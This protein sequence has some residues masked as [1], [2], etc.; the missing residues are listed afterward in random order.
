VLLVAVA[1]FGLALIPVLAIQPNL[2]QPTFSMRLPIVGGVYIVICMLGIL[3]VFYPAKCKEVFQKSQNPMPQT[4]KASM[5]I[6]GHHPN[7][8]KYEPNRIKLQGRVF[9]AACS[10]LL[11]G[12]VIAVIGA[13]AYFFLGI[14][15]WVGGIWLLVLGEV[16]MVLGLIQIRF[17]GYVKV[18]A[19]L[20]FVVGSLLVLVE[21]DVLVGGIL[22]DLYVLGLITFML[23]LRILLSE[24]NN[25]RTCMMCQ[26][27]G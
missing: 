7:C 23:W 1:L 6:S 2:A 27:C 17:A 4:E 5:Q 21:A 9:C 13:A 22:A 11:A 15:F 10:G 8:D 12:G 26:S 18:V 24:W 16:M 14:N 19:N 3:A 25:K 20:V